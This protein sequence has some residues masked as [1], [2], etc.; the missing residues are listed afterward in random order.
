MPTRLPVKDIMTGLLKNML[1]AIRF[2]LHSTLVAISWLAIVPLT[3]CRIYRCLFAGSVSSLLTL[4]LDMLS[5]DNIIS[6]ILQGGF[7]VLC[8]LGAFISLVWL[9]EQILSGGGPDW[10]E[11]AHLNQPNNNNNNNNNRNQANQLN[12]NNQN[13]APQQPQP[14]NHPLIGNNLFNRIPAAQPA[15]QPPQP[16]N[17]P[18]NQQIENNEPAPN[19]QEPAAA[20]PQQQQ[21]ENNAAAAAANDDNHWNPIE[22]DRAA[23]DLT[24]DR[25][26]GLDGLLLFLEHVF[27]VISLNTLFIL[28]FAFCPYHLGHY[29]V[30]GFKFQ[31]YV[32]KTH[33]EG[34][35]TT[36]V[37]YV[38]IALILVMLYTCM[39]V[40]SF[41]RARKVGLFHVYFCLN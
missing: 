40:W 7:V 32:D 12:Q 39:A 28:V 20:A 13:Q 11:N 27:W 24:W 2:W 23:E 25:L 3:A 19:N 15:Q 21:Q 14:H 41:H 31:D 1:K 38:M 37:G 22:W 29:G 34:L 10:L 36:L 5:T 17:P 30:Y 6:D 9:R 4:P 26:L 35:V 33:F 16:P 8:S 18:P